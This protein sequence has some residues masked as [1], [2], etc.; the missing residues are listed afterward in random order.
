MAILQGWKKLLLVSDSSPNPLEVVEVYS[1]GFST[2]NTCVSSFLP[3][4]TLFVN[5][6][7][8]RQD[9]QQ[10][11]E[12]RLSS[13][14]LANADLAQSSRLA[15]L[16]ST[17][18]LHGPLLDTAKRAYLFSDIQ[19]RRSSASTGTDNRLWVEKLIPSLK[20]DEVCRFQ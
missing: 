18:F 13:G 1:K 7:T 14:N 15:K 5:L 20:V 8:G 17:A 12:L 2:V 3:L 16:P 4:V 6:V 19:R 9:E 10:Q 11:Q